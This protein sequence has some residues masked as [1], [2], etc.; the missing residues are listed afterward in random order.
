MVIDQIIDISPV[1]IGADLLILSEELILAV[2]VDRIVRNMVKHT[3]ENDVHTV[4]FR[5]RNHLFKI[6]Q[7]T[8]NGI[9]GHI[10]AGIVS[11]IG[12]GTEHGV[13]IDHRHS[14]RFQVF[15]LLGNTLQVTAVN[16]VG[17][18]TITLECGIGLI[19]ARDE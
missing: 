19:R 6:A 4:G 12:N 15:N 3:I 8:Q 1:G 9:N 18:L 14:Q 2:K 17:V 7:R 16:L 5:C 10:I 13:Q 11:V